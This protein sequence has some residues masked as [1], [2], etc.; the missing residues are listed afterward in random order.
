MEPLLPPQSSPL[1]QWHTKHGSQRLVNGDLFLPWGL[2]ITVGNIVC[3]LW[4]VAYPFMWV[5]NA[6]LL[7]TGIVQVSAMVLSRRAD[8]RQR[9]A[10]DEQRATATAESRENMYG[11]PNPEDA[12]QSART[13]RVTYRSFAEPTA[14]PQELDVPRADARWLHGDKPGTVMWWPQA[15]YDES[16]HF[17]WGGQAILMS[18]DNDF[19]LPLYEQPAPTAAD[20]SWLTKYM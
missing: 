11:I 2:G 7:L 16:G 9:A 18:P 19:N 14:P 5:L 12:K 13:I 1:A 20:A 17:D 15:G 8:R 3:Q 6:I 4:L 10:Y